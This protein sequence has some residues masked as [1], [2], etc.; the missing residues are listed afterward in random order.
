MKLPS[1]L[2]LSIIA[3]IWFGYV[4]GISFLEAPLKFQAPGITLPLGLG[5]GRIVFRTLNKIEIVFAIVISCIAFFKIKADVI[6]IVTAL[7]FVILAIQTFWLLPFLDNKAEMIIKGISA[8]PS[9]LHFFYIALEALKL[10]LLFV[11][12]IKNLQIQFNEKI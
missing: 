7:L 3:F 12:G 11:I 9:Q 2:Y 6:K 8:P 4:A 5:I 1:A 10:V